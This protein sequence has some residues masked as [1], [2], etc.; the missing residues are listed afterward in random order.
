MTIPEHY[1]CKGVGVSCSPLCIRS[2]SLL[3]FDKKLGP[4]PRLRARHSRPGEASYRWRYCGKRE[5]LRKGQLRGPICLTDRDLSRT[6]LTVAVFGWVGL[7]HDNSR[8]RSW[9]LW[10]YQDVRK[11]GRFPW[12]SLRGRITFQLF[13][14]CDLLTL[15]LT[16]TICAG[17]ILGVRQ[18][19]CCY[20]GIMMCKYSAYLLTLP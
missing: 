19:C 4:F 5:L 11:S 9:K 7:L 18:Y 2:G 15:A 12:R 6:S 17:R 3:R 10:L 20:C 1:A 8:T 13:C 16:Y 14:Y